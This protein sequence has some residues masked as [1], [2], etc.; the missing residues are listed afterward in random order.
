MNLA[1]LLKPIIGLTPIAVE[2]LAAI[3][4]AI[5]GG[6]L[7]ST[8]TAVITARTAYPKPNATC[9]LAMRAPKVRT[10]SMCSKGGNF[11]H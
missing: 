7:S 9:C 10:A 2:V 4:S 8:V 11:E 5:A 6:P 1:Q 3:G